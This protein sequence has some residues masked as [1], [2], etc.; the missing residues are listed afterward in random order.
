MIMI[1]MEGTQKWGRVIYSDMTSSPPQWD[2]PN[3]RDAF[4]QNGWGAVDHFIWYVAYLCI[5]RATVMSLYRDFSSLVI[6][7]GFWAFW[8]QIQ[9]TDCQ[10]VNL[11]V[12]APPTSTCLEQVQQLWRPC[13]MY[14]PS[15]EALQHMIQNLVTYNQH[16]GVLTIP[17]PILSR[18]PRHSRHPRHTTSAPDLYRFFLRWERVL[19]SSWG[20]WSLFGG[21]THFNP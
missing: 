16:I 8:A 2:A 3:A 6:L 20:F 15:D 13:F 1:L 10:I 7:L 17:P 4:H 19:T 18:A 5:L 9:Y 14:C 11:D 12:H 21:K